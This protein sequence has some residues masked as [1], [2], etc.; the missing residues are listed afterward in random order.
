MYPTMARRRETKWT[1]A[2][3]VLKG[4]GL[5]VNC[6]RQARMPTRLRFLPFDKYGP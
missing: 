2:T 3:S 4:N 6:Q 1:E 5:S